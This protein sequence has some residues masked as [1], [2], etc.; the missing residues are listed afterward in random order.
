ML[1]GQNLKGGTPF[2]VLFKD[3]GIVYESFQNKLSNLGIFFFRNESTNRIF[4]VWICESG[5]ANRL[6]LKGF[7]IRESGFLR[8][9]FV[10]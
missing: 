8:I 4:R 9:R 5:F 3:A 1:I 10:L 7:K 2:W 6:D